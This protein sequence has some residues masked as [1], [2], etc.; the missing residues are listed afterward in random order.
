MKG[1]DLNRQWQNPR[2]NTTK[3]WGSKLVSMA[4]TLKIVS[5]QNTEPVALLRKSD[6]H[7]GITW[8]G[9][10]ASLQPSFFCHHVCLSPLLVVTTSTY[11]HLCLSLP[12]LVTTVACRHHHLPLNYRNPHRQHPRPHAVCAGNDVLKNPVECSITALC[13]IDFTNR[14][15]GLL[16]LL[17]LPSPLLSF[18]YSYK[19]ILKKLPKNL[20]GKQGTSVASTYHYF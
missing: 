11:H 19:R 10:E 8:S 4:I 16:L 1:V 15:H 17:L 6:L 2:P 12:L 14:D 18:F 13:G 7:T 20:F 5:R 3:G 9:G